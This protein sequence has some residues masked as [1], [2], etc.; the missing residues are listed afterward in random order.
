[1]MLPNGLD[2]LFNLVTVVASLMGNGCS[3]LSAPKFGAAD[4]GWSTVVT[5]NQVQLAH[6]PYA[7]RGSG[8]AEATKD[9]NF[10]SR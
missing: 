6:P 4:I 3:V 1:M 5:E 7:Q 10:Y 8:D 9:R 2:N